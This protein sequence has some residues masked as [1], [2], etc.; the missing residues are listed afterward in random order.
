MSPSITRTYLQP[1]V[2][3]LLLLGGL[4]LSASASEA[5][6]LPANVVSSPAPDYPDPDIQVAS[7]E[8]E[9]YPVHMVISKP[10]DA[11]RKRLEEL[12]AAMEQDDSE[13]AFAPGLRCPGEDAQRYRK[14]VSVAGFALETRTQ[15]S[16]GNLF[17]AEH[18][19]P[20]MLYQHLL[21]SGEVQ[22]YFV[23]GRQMYASLD[24]AP[25]FSRSD[26][27]L[28]KFSG[29]SRE[30]GVQFV[31]SGVIRTVAVADEDTWGTSTLNTIR[32]TLRER[33][34]TRHFAVDLAVHDG[35]SG[36]VVMEKRY[37]TSGEWTPGLT[38]NV[39]FGTAEFAATP[40][41]EA[42]ENLISKISGDIVDTLDC[43]P[44]LVR[45]TEA[46]GR[47][48][49]LDAGV[50]SGLKPGDSLR[51]LRSSSSWSRHGAPPELRDTGVDVVLSQ[52]TLDS[53]RGSIDQEV[54][55]INIQ[56]GDYAVIW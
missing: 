2:V 37:A 34:K 31:I 3:S 45:I 12:K 23:P 41:G 15:A 49:V 21:T 30:M 35:F 52:V 51:L 24:S 22:P 43:Q 25:T 4:P 54:G 36:R 16:M 56:P 38:E 29:L 19:M 6:S 28:E 9:P 42:V 44:L 48:L 27:R 55:M 47:R 18:E 11:D 50:K 17:S 26:N 14:R 1:A 5:E 32:R 39:G 13:E 10:V 8:E 46:D 40:Y 7:L 53:V 20:A 33:N